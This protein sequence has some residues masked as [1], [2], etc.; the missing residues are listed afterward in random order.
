MNKSTYTDSGNE[1]LRTIMPRLV[2]VIKSNN[3]D[4]FNILFQYKTINKGMIS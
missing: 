4:L 1:I 3:P 2:A